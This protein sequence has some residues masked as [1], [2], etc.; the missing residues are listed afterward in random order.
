VN[1]WPSYASTSALGTATY[2]AYLDQYMLKVAPPVLSFDHYPLLENGITA[3]YFYNWAEIRRRALGAGVPSWGFIQSV[4]FGGSG[5]LRRRRPDERELLWQVN[6]GLAYGAKGVQYFTYWTPDPPPD[7]PIWF[8]Q[9][10]ISREAQRTSL[11]YAAGRV[12]AYLRVIGGRLLSLLSESVVHAGERNL[13]RGARAFRKDTYVTSR[14]GS[15]VIL[16]R[17]R[18]PSGSADRHLLVVNRSFRKEADARLKLA[19]RLNR[20]YE[21]DRATGD[22]ARVRLRGDPSRYLRVRLAP[23]AARLYLLRSA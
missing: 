8:G 6:V 2:E 23:G 20:V 10:L 18:N 22:Y 13:P 11:Y 7:A 17:F 9:A 1:V 16:S 21:V 14:S 4:D 12:N 19:A 3:D 5:L 15:P